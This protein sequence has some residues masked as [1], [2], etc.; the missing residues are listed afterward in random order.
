MRRL[1]RI[2]NFRDDLMK[3]SESC[4]L[5]RRSVYEQLADLARLRGWSSLGCTF[6]VRQI[7][8]EPGFWLVGLEWERE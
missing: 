6:V 3:N 5:Y 4:V 2:V 1:Y 7:R 8:R